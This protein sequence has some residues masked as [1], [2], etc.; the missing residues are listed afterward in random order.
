MHSPEYRNIMLKVA[1]EKNCQCID[2]AKISTDYFNF[3]SRNYVN[4]LYL[5]LPAGKYPAWKD[6]VDDNSHYTEKGAKV[7]AQMIAVDIQFKRKIKIFKFK[8][9]TNS[10]FRV[11][12]KACSYKNKRNYTKKSWKNMIKQR[13]NAWKV[14]YTP[15]STNQQCK[16]AQHMLINVLRKMKKIK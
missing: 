3:R 11:Y 16:T 2:L 15:N 7:V 1:K 6:G 4:S 14:L 9:N 13:N 8:K 10:L 5:K 12:K